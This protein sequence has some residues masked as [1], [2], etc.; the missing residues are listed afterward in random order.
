MVLTPVATGE[1]EDLRAR[2]RA[3]P[4]RT[5][6]GRLPPTHFARFVVMPLDDRS[7]LL[8]SARFDGRREDYI[9][10]LAVTPEAQAIWS[11]CELPP[12]CELTE[13]LQ[14]EANH[15]ATQ[16]IVAAIDEQL[17]VAQVNAALRLRA[18]LSRFVTRVHR[19]DAAEL[20]HEFRQLTHLHSVMGDGGR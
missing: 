4:P 6:T 14:D 12:C 20:A 8:F 9:A 18:Q 15:L 7:R 19:L 17:S 3:L 10:A 13:Y 16:Y 5:F 2:L 11:H 1:E